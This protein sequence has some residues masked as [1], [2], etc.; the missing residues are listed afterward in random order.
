M[1]CLSVNSAGRWDMLMNFFGQND[2]ALCHVPKGISILLSLK[3]KPTTTITKS[4]NLQG[5]PSVK[6]R[7]Y[8][9]EELL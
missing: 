6:T 1:S 8:N 2:S 3:H 5:L 9:I 4:K 7:Y